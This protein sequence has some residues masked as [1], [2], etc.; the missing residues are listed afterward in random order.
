MGE[1]AVLGNGEDENKAEPSAVP[2]ERFK[3]E[4]IIAVSL[5]VKGRWEQEVNM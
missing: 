1:N 3:G 5:I 4:P 2:L